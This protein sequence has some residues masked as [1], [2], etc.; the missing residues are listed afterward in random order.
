MKQYTLII[1]FALLTLFAVPL[2]AQDEA[3]SEPTAAAT[4]EAT[5]EASGG[6]VINVEAPDVPETPAPVENST[7]NTLTLI[8]HLGYWLVIITLAF[9]LYSSNKS[10]RDMVSVDTVKALYKDAQGVVGT[11]TSAIPG[12]IDDAIAEMI[13]NRVKEVIDRQ[14]SPPETAAPDKSAG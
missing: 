11:I 10:V 8:Q 12:K 7:V 5:Q 13:L 6:V 1:L 9:L 14:A 4:V 3:T 2:L